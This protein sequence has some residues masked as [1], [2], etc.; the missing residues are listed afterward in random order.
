MVLFKSELRNRNRDYQVLSTRRDGESGMRMRQ[1]PAKAVRET[2]SWNIVGRRECIEQRDYAREA[3]F[4]Q[5]AR[6]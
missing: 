1:R 5:L 3:I 6:V 4:W 2:R